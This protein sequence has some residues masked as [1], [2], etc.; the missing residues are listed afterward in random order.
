MP[1]ISTW[2]IVR[3]RSKLYLKKYSASV[4]ADMTVCD[5]IIN[6][7]RDLFLFVLF[8][9]CYDTTKKRLGL[10]GLNSRDITASDSPSVLEATSIEKNKYT[11]DS[12]SWCW[13][14]ARNSWSWWATLLITIIKKDAFQASPWH[15]KS[16]FRQYWQSTKTYRSSLPELIDMSPITNSA[17]LQI[18]VIHHVTITKRFL[19]II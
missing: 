10:N 11:W 4:I 7:W 19:L 12:W 16:F 6:T 13:R 18:S 15:G 17:W 5:S 14:L 9:E 8:P 1:V 2:H 3:S